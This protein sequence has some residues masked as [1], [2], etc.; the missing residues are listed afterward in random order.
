MGFST[1]LAQ[2]NDYIIGRGIIFFAS[3]NAAGFPLEFR[4]LGNA[5]EFSAT[6][7]TEKLE[8]QSSRA[9]LK[10]TDKEVVVA[11]SASISFTV[12]EINLDNLALWFSGDTTSFSQSAT[13]VVGV[14]NVVLSLAK[15]GV[16]ESALGKWY[17]LYVRADMSSG[18]AYPGTSAEVRMYNIADAGF[19]AE[20][21][22]ST[23]LTEGTDYQVDRIM[24]RIFL[25]DT[26]ANRAEFPLGTE[27]LDVDWTPVAQTIEEV[28]GLTVSE[29]SGALQFIQKNAANN[30]VQTEYQF[31]SVTLSPEGDLAMLGD[32]FSTMQFTGKAEAREAVDASAPVVRIRTYSQ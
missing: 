22:G 19:A 23:A 16:A 2:P 24:G 18:T 4:D 3:V 32:E 5:P 17:L 27:T 30:S 6:L 28:A 8:H 20:K 7:E 15:A 10:V 21:T 26:T 11:I 12:D 25:Y 14:E 13:P 29:I 9:G 31:H 1:G